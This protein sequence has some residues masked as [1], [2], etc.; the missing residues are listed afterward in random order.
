MLKIALL[1][2]CTL[3]NLKITGF[4]VKLDYNSQTQV[5]LKSQLATGYS[6]SQFF[7]AKSNKKEAANI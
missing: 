4:S 3:A 7:V 5:F 2:F 1:G 6:S